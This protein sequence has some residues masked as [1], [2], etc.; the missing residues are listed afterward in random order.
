MEEQLPD[1][2]LL[3]DNMDVILQHTEE[4][5]QCKAY[6]YSRIAYDG[7]QF[8]DGVKSIPLGPWVE[9]WKHAPINNVSKMVV[10]VDY[11]GD[12]WWYTSEVL[13]RYGSE[14]IPIKGLMKE[15]AGLLIRNPL[16]G[17]YYHQLYDIFYRYLKQF[18]KPDCPIGAPFNM[19]VKELQERK[20]IDARES[21]AYD[22]LHNQLYNKVKMIV[23]DDRFRYVPFEDKYKGWSRSPYHPLQKP[24]SFQLKLENDLSTTLIVDLAVPAKYYDSDSVGVKKG[25]GPVE[26]MDLLNHI[27]D[28]QN[29]ALVDSGFTKIKS[30][31]S[32][33]AVGI[34]AQ[35]SYKIDSPLDLIEQ[36]SVE[37]FTNLLQYLYRTIEQEN[38]L[39]ER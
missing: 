5:L 25:K 12:S 9:F 28:L 35:Y 6:Y 23:G 39:P 20:P 19:V 17:L 33:G 27:F 7:K 24:V 18:E 15:K 37:R 34:S 36:K 32:L 30:Y 3:E 29:G 4:I 1:L 21:Q 31:V 2:L 11:L 26:R 8:E 38:L 16:P 14:N 13:H 22:D 10:T